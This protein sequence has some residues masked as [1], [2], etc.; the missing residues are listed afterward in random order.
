MDRSQDYPAP[1]MGR[2]AGTLGAPYSPPTW[3]RASEYERIPPAAP[4]PRAFGSAE[5]IAALVT[6]GD[7]AAEIGVASGHPTSWIV[8]AHANAAM[9][10]FRDRMG[11]AGPTIHVP[12]G[13]SIRVDSPFTHLWAFN[14]TGGANAVLNAI[15]E[16]DRA[17]PA[18]DSE[19]G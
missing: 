2:G 7:T 14:H 17:A 6:L 4:Q 9:V 13:T 19:T 15:A 3:P 16:Y 1:R 5:T 12:A 10:S 8:A 11:R 18:S